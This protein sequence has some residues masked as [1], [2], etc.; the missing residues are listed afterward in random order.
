MNI[1]QEHDIF[2]LTVNDIHRELYQIKPK[3]RSLIHKPDPYINHSV[4][5][6]TMYEI[7]VHCLHIPKGMPVV[8]ASLFFLRGK[9]ALVPANEVASWFEKY[10]N[11]FCYL[12]RDHLPI[13]YAIWIIYTTVNRW[14]WTN[15]PTDLEIIGRIRY[16]YSVGVIIPVDVITQ[17]WFYQE[18]L[19]KGEQAIAKNKVLLQEFK[20]LETKVAN[21]FDKSGSWNKHHR[22]QL[23][24]VADELRITYKELV[25][26]MKPDWKS[27]MKHH[28]KN[29]AVKQKTT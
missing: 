19:S 11:N 17:R 22:A 3:P 8:H 25:S 16:L 29:L 10:T 1:T 9:P 24:T 18:G 27:I 15:E 4:Y 7:D 23:N 2:S 13:E 26:V 5:Y 20:L 6:S 12:N 28:N 21:Y 14:T